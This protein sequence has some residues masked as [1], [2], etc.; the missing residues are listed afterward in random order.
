MFQPVYRYFK[1][2]GNSN[3]VT[4]WK[5]NGLSDESIKKPLLHHISLNPGINYSD[6]EK[7]WLKLERSC[8]KKETETITKKQVVNIYIV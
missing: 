1:M 7:I 2:V 3:K 6:N 5:T 4:V 8:P